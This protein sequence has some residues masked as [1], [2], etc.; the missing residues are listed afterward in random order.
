MELSYDQHFSVARELVAGYLSA[1]ALDCDDRHIDSL[2]VQLLMLCFLP[3][4][5]ADVVADSS[6]DRGYLRAELAALTADQ[7]IIWHRLFRYASGRLA[8]QFGDCSEAQRKLILY[9]SWRRL[10]RYW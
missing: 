8:E 7:R 4:A 3:V 1:Y 5:E 9:S 2:S 10:T 6:L